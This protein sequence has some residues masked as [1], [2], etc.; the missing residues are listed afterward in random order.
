M[1]LLMNSQCYVYYM[2]DINTGKQNHPN[3]YNQY[4]YNSVDKIRQGRMRVAETEK[5]DKKEE[6]VTSWDSS[7]DKATFKADIKR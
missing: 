1:A 6:A 7:I 3:C 2:D 4:D 5:S